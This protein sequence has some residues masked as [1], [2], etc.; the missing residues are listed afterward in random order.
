MLSKKHL[1]VE[2]LRRLFLLSMFLK[3]FDGLVELLGGIALAIVTQKNIVDIVHWLTRS[4]LAEDPHDFIATHLEHFAAHFSVGAK[5]FAAGYL[6]A[7]GVLKLFLVACLLKNYRWAY[8][9]AIVIM[10]GFIAFESVRLAQHPS[11]LLGF[12]TALDI[13]IV[14]VIFLEWRQI[15]S[16]KEPPKLWG[17]KKKNTAKPA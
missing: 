5:A 1:S 16:G 17:R 2:N 15:K 12:V 9:V 10:F 3:G 8:P 7:H 14:I 6:I 4:E 13:S 11:I